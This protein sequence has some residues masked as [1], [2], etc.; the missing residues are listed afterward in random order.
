MNIIDLMFEAYGEIAY[1]ILESE[2]E[3]QHA[4]RDKRRGPTGR[5]TGMGSVHMII[6]GDKRLDTRMKE[7]PVRKQV[8]S[9]KPLKGGR[10]WTDQAR[11]ER[12]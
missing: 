6:G 2:R 3:E 4:R 7:G 11:N 10:R 8:H 5:I 9:K 1:A 12:R